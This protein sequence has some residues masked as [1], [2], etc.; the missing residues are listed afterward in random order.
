MKKNKKTIE[1]SLTKITNLN[2]RFI[3]ILQIGELVNY[4]NNCNK[5]KSKQGFTCFGLFKYKL[6]NN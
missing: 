4:H 1:T 6:I 2:E 5:C 3:T